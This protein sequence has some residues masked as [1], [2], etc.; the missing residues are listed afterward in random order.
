MFF[1]R[2]M[3]LWTLRMNFW[4]PV[5]VSFPEARKVTL[6]VSEGKKIFRETNFIKLFLCT[7]Q[8]QFCQV[9]QRT[10]G[11]I[12]FGKYAKTKSLWI[13]HFSLRMMFSTCKRLFW[14]PFLVFFIKRLGIFR[15]KYKNDEKFR[16]IG[17]KHFFP[18]NF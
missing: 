8:K 3:F 15:L 14:Q 4:Q 1:T 6:K 13:F 11:H 7:R 16:K 18:K 17:K 12:F 10:F 2:K 5:W 9:G